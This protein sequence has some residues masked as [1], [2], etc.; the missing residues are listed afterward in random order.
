LERAKALGAA[1][2][3]NYRTTPSWDEE[4]LRLTDGKGVDLIL[5]NGGAQTT[6]K[7]FNCI[8][9]GGTIAAIGYVSGKMDPPEDRININ[10]RALAR[11]VTIKGLLNGPRDRLEELLEFAA[12]HSVK[13]VIDRVF[14]FDEAKTALEYLWS[15]SHFGKVIIQF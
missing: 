3:I 5:E 14:S 11:N 2:T 13:P 15:G 9:F 7:S 12:K 1:H 6:S 4:V 10:V 8:A